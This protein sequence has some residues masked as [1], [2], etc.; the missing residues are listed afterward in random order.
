VLER[1][2]KMLECTIRDFKIEFGIDRDGCLRVADVI[3]ADSW[4]LRDKDG[5]E[6]SKQL[7]RDD[8]PLAEVETAYE[9]VSNLT[10][11]FAIPKQGILFLRKNE[12]DPIPEAV[13]RF[14]EPSI[15]MRIVAS[16]EFG[17][18]A[19]Y[20]DGLHGVEAE[21][22][23]GLVVINEVGLTKA[24]AFNA[25]NRLVCPVI[26]TKTGRTEIGPL[27]TTLP[28]AWI[29]QIENALEY[30]LKI[31]AVSNPAAYM[32]HKIKEEERRR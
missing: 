17:S 13:A 30:A 18:W 12:S 19:A 16:N 5:N 22:P 15:E 32:L 10:A 11:R 28:V 6:L 14:K 1:A 24:N 31:F 25:R 20:R 7:F 27:D 29:P 23:Q 21:F 2:W 26:A 9:I 8:H 3:D 4:R